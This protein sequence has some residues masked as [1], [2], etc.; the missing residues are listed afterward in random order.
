MSCS[1]RHK[2]L[3]K[4]CIRMREEGK[5]H[6]DLTFEDGNV[7]IDGEIVWKDVARVRDKT[8]PRGDPYNNEFNQDDE[9]DCADIAEHDCLCY[10][11]FPNKAQAI[12]FLNANSYRHMSSPCDDPYT[13]IHWWRMGGKSAYDAE[14]VAVL[15]DIIEYSDEPYSWKDAETLS[16]SHIELKTDHG[17]HYLAAFTAA[18][19]VGMVD[20]SQ[21]EILMDFSDRGC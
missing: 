11:L 4:A 8:K 6:L 5:P 18:A 1:S 2:L 21:G 20:H 3:R 9:D 10:G 14:I 19:I 13:N 17:T 16:N 7:C 12:A 15:R